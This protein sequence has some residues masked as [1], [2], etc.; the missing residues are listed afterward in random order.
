M[1]NPSM[2]LM[3]A[4]RISNAVYPQCISE[5]GQVAFRWSRTRWP[6]G[7]HECVQGGESAALL[8][9]RI[10]QESAKPWAFRVQ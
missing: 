9:L 1:Q 4:R 8:A 10:F 5:L 6:I 3:R 7:S 2:A